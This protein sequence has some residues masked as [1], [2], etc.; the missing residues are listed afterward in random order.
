M[1]KFRVSNSYRPKIERLEIIRETP[2][3]YVFSK[4][5]QERREQPTTMDHRWFDDFDSAKDFLVGY[6]GVRANDAKELHEQA[7]A[8]E[9]PNV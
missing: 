8:I 2:S 5:G 3:M 4:N 7:L 1:T 9:A 6:Y